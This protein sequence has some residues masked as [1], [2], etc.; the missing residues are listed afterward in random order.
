MLV[1]QSTEILLRPGREGCKSSASVVTC[2][3]LRKSTVRLWFCDMD[4][5]HF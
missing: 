5:K 2:L 4:S 1:C 3:L